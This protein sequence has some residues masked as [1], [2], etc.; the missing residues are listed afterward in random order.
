M[1]MIRCCLHDEP[2]ERPRTGQLVVDLEQM[3]SNIADPFGDAARI[4]VMRQIA[5]MRAIQE[6]ET[7]IRE[8]NEEIERLRQQ[9][10]VQCTLYMHNNYCATNTGLT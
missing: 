9:I 6:R 10:Q 1:E 2:S 3:R 4:D 7:E 8:K 5:S